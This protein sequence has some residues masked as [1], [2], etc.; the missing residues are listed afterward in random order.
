M[1]ERE[2]KSSFIIITCCNLSHHSLLRVG[3]HFVLTSCN[4][5]KAE[6]SSQFAAGVWRRGE[7]DGEGQEEEEK[8]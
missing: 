4:W 3:G 6:I 8:K 2:L 7:Q 1:R 5:T